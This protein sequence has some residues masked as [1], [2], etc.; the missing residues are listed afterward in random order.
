MEINKEPEKATW[1]KSRNGSFYLP[2]M[3]PCSMRRKKGVRKRIITSPP[4]IG[5]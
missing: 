3:M 2:K 5:K 4:S 1:L